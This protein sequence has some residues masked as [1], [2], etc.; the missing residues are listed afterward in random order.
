MVKLAVSRQICKEW[1][2]FR[3][4]IAKKSPKGY[5]ERMARHRTEIPDTSGASAKEILELATANNVR[6][7]RLQFTDILGVNKNVEIPAP[8]FENGLA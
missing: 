5:V 4:G 3:A 8:Q 6:F 2:A 7:L 1:C